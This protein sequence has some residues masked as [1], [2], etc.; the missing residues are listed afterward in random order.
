GW[1]WTTTPARASGSRSTGRVGPVRAGNIRKDGKHTGA[2]RPPETGHRSRRAAPP[3]AGACRRR[4]DPGPGHPAVRVGAGVLRTP[5]HRAARHLRDVG[6][7]PD[8]G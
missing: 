1:A 7:E 8:P 6:D 2:R 5:V 4:A 3:Q